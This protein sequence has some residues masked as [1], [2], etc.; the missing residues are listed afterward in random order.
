MYLCSNIILM[1][2][3]PNPPMTAKC[4]CWSDDWKLMTYEQQ[5]VMARNV[6]LRNV[7][8]HSAVTGV[9]AKKEDI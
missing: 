8:H 3:N 1:G 4:K 9:R 2:E 6:V 7:F 5:D